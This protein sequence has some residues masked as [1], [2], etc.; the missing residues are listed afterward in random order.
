MSQPT[1]LDDVFTESAD[2]QYIEVD[3]VNP[4][5]DEEIVTGSIVS[6][7][8]TLRSVD[9]GEALFL[10][11]D[12]V[13]TSRSS[14]P[15]GAGVTRITFT[16]ADMSAKGT[17]ELQTRLLTLK[18]VHSAGKVWHGAVQFPLGNLRDVP[19]TG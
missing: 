8:G 6:I 9:T 14:Y 10:N 4:S 19:V 3:L 16:A 11:E 18:V 13:A 5:N 12:L 7:H 1:I 15:G 17:R 2:G